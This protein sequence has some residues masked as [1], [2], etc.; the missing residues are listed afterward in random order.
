MRRLV[1]A[2][3]LFLEVAVCCAIFASSLELSRD[4]QRS[5]G[6]TRLAHAVVTSTRQ[7]ALEVRV[8]LRHLT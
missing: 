5:P 6:V 7:I 8:S 2:L 4:L 1:I 3:L